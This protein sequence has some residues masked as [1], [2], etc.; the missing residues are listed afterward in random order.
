[1]DIL[2][3]AK[4]I[5][6]EIINLRR[7]IHQNPELSFQEFKTA[8]LVETYLRKLP[9]IKVIRNHDLRMELR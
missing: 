4:N 2:S 3:M 7:I 6:K 9:H 1:M 5:E 8:K